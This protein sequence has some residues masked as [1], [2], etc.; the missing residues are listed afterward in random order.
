[1]NQIV[2]PKLQSD[3]KY[4]SVL[5]ASVC[6]RGVGGWGGRERHNNL[7]CYYAHYTADLRVNRKGLGRKKLRMHSTWHHP[8]R[9]DTVIDL[10]S[11]QMQKRPRWK[12]V[13]L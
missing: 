2:A 5:P 11:S 3:S 4:P 8:W 10:L 7:Y 9:G 6:D 1:M 12:C 13:I